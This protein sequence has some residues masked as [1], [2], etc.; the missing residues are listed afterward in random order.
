MPLLCHDP[1]RYPLGLGYI[2]FSSV[3]RARE[4][5]L[6]VWLAKGGFLPSAKTCSI[7]GSTHKVAYHAENYY[8]LWTMNE[9]CQSCHS[10]LH[11]RFWQLARTWR[12]LI[13]THT[14]TREEWFMLTPRAGEADQDFAGYLRYRFGDAYALV[15]R[16]SLEGIV[17]D[18]VVGQVPANLLS[19]RHMPDNGMS[20][21]YGLPKVYAE[22]RVQPVARPA[23][24]GPIRRMFPERQQ[25]SLLDQMQGAEA[26]APNPP[27]TRTIRHRT[28][29]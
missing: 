12:N 28:R 7:C 8:D 16:T 29:L 24:R 17:P 1:F 4:W 22:D 18:R 13:E 15:E 23:T 21:G 14:K 6:Q 26:Q 5:Q 10:V 20:L 2:G 11:R 27:L 3:E 19:A 25:P 9:I